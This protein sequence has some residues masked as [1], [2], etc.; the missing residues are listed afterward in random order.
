[1]Y[2][3]SFDNGDGG[4]DFDRGEFDEFNDWDATDCA[5][6]DYNTFEENQLAQEY[7]GW[8]DDNSFP[9]DYDEFDGEAGAD[10]EF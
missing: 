1:M 10:A 9:T 5:N 2:D 8:D 4:N 3:H 6:G 7:E